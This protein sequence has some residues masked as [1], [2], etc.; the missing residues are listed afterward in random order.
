[1]ARICVFLSTKKE[2]ENQFETDHNDLLPCIVNFFQV[3][4]VK[5]K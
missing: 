5:L 4:K 2:K 3:S 1:M